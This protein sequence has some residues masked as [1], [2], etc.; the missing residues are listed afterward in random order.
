M[1]KPPILQ[2][3]LLALLLAPALAIQIGNT[4]DVLH[5]FQ[6]ATEMPEMPFQIKMATRELGTGPDRNSQ[7]LAIDGKPVHSGRQLESILLSK[8]PGDTV[9]VLISQPDGRAVE[10]SVRIPGMVPTAGIPVLTATLWITLD[11][12]IPWLVLIL[13]GYVV[14]ARPKDLSAWLLLLL[15]LGF[16]EQ[17][18]NHAWD[19]PFPN[20]TFAWTAVG[21]SVWPMAMLLFGVYF[22]ERSRGDRKRPWVKFLFLIP[23]LGFPAFFW[24]VQGIW[25]NDINAALAWR[26][27]FIRIY[28]FQTLVAMAAISSYFFNIGIKSGTASSPDARRRLRILWIGTGISLSPMLTIALFAIATGQDFFRG[29]PFPLT[30]ISLL[31]LLLF[32]VTLAYVIVIERAMDVRFVVRQSVRYGVLKRGLWVLRFAVL[33]AGVYLL[34]NAHMYTDRWQQV[35]LVA[36]GATLL[37]VRKSGSEKLSQWIDRR[38]FRDAYDAEQVLTGLAAQAGRFLEIGPLLQTVSQKL[39]STLH[40]PDVTILLRTSDRLEPSYSTYIGQPWGIDAAGNLAALLI[41]PLSV[42]LSSPKPWMANLCGEDLQALD[43]MRSE[44]LLPLQGPAGLAGVISLGPKRSEVPYS[45]ADIRLLQAVATQVGLAV[46]NS[47]LAESLAVE[48]GHRERLNRELEIAREVQQRLFPQKLPSVSGVEYAGVCR[49]AQGVGGDYYDFIAR[50]NGSFAIAIGDVSGK[51]IAAALLM[52]SLQASLR[53][54]TLTDL[55]D[56]SRLMRNVNRLIYEASTR[57]RFATIFYAE[58]D[59]ATLLLN[60]VNAGHN[61]P[62]ILRESE[63]LRLTPGGPAVGLLAS[64]N[65]NAATIQLQRG[66]VLVAFTDGLSEAMNANFGEWEEEQ[67][68]ALAK[69]ARH[70]PAAQL[71]QTLFA[72]A[73]A[74]ADGAPQHDD[75][76]LIILK[77]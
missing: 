39:T 66:D 33:T 55:H 62:A 59:P 38:F 31:F 41:K 4:G 23:G 22:P 44:L 7:L 3:T 58:F 11:L 72:G 27:L 61:S 36:L 26:P 74:F 69:N 32:P 24:I 18:R 53:G 71:I 73:D 28:F 60:F 37:V 40:V 51:G 1:T 45:P 42:D 19:G 17:A 50:P 68:L 48:A 2:Y 10:R 8:K 20:L 43:R 15:L 76:T 5:R 12:V 21:V 13:G 34:S 75:M 9:A 65:F 35:E 6:H 29:V 64:S 30:V 63:T 57:N 52:A 25:R 67:F 54:Q 56:L 47:R 77:L 46:E 14:A 49:P 16:G 70:Q